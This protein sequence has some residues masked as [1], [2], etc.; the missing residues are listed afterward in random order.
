MFGIDPAVLLIV[1]LSAVSAGAIC[2]GVLYSRIET[3]KKA[4]SRVN[5]KAA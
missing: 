3:Q 5:R 4:E 2:Y 1:L